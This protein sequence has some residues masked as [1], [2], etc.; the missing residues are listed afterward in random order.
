MRIGCRFHHGTM[1][2][3]PCHRDRHH[4][5]CGMVIRFERFDGFDRGVMLGRDGD[6]THLP[7]RVVQTVAE[8]A[9][10]AVRVDVRAQSRTVLW[11]DRPEIQSSHVFDVLEGDPLGCQHGL[12]DRETR[13]RLAPLDH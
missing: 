4:N 13:R 10:T 2:V 8:T 5:R 12:A 6:V 1:P 7:D 9:D 3:L 11:M